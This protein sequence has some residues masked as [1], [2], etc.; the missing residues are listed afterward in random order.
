MRQA[1]AMSKRKKLTDDDRVAREAEEMGELGTR[2]RKK[3]T[4]HR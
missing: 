4:R 1:H 3:P 2:Q